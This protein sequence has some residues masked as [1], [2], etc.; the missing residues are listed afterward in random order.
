MINS[1]KIIDVQPPDVPNLDDDFTDIV[2]WTIEEE[3]AFMTILNSTK[4]DEDL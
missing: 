2:E 3:E 4:E 1:R